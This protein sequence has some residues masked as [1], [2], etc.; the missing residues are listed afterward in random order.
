MSQKINPLHFFLKRVADGDRSAI[1][2]LTNKLAD[3]LV[4]VPTAAPGLGTRARIEKVQVLKIPKNGAACV[5]I[6][7]S[8]RLFQDWAKKDDH[9]GDSISL[10]C[11]DLAIAL[12][13][14][15]ATT[16]FIV[17]YGSEHEATLDYAVIKAISESA[18]EEIVYEDDPS[19]KSKKKDELNGSQPEERAPSNSRVKLR[20]EIAV[21]T[22]VR[23]APLE[24]ISDAKHPIPKKEEEELPNFAPAQ[25]SKKGIFGAL[26][27]LF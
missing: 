7:T 5:P 8:S 19:L 9:Q 2:K 25:E 10:L 1:S 20:E 16:S 12:R 11:A 6:F 17:D 3:K 18:P 14:E 24:M 13:N 23:R 21:S 15:D 4:Y 26:R 22:A 27:S